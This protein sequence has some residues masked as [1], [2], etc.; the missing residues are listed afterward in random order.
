MDHLSAPIRRAIICNKRSLPSRRSLQWDRSTSRLR[1]SIG[2]SHRLEES[3][4]LKY[5]T[6]LAYLVRLAHPSPFPIMWP[7]R[8]KGRLSRFHYPGARRVL[9]LG[10]IGGALLDIH[11]DRPPALTGVLQML[12]D[13]VVIFL[14][15]I[16]GSLAKETCSVIRVG[17]IGLVVET[18]MGQL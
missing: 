7:C 15:S 5:R 4:E 3:L 2:E 16:Q 6:P 9:D 10:G 13:R 17:L 18:R 8:P 11:H 14:P 1:P 12:C